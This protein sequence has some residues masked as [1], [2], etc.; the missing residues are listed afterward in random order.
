MTEERTNDDARWIPPVDSTW[1]GRNKIWEN[2]EDEG[3]ESGGPKRRSRGGV[4][5]LELL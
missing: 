1:K 2:D 3:R 4:A 5:G